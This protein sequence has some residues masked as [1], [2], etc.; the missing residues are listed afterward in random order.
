MKALVIASLT[1]SVLH[2]AA[3]ASSLLRGMLPSSW[4]QEDLQEQLSRHLE[5]TDDLDARDFHCDNENKFYF[6]ADIVLEFPGNENTC[7]AEMA[8]H[9]MT[10]DDLYCEIM[11]FLWEHF[12]DIVMLE[13]EMNEVAR[14]DTKVCEM[15]IARGRRNL[16]TYYGSGSCRW[17]YRKRRRLS[18]EGDATNM[19][20][21]TAKKL[22][23]AAEDAFNWAQKLREIAP[24]L[25]PI[26]PDGS[27]NV[28]QQSMNMDVAGMKMAED[29]EAV[30]QIIVTTQ[31]Y[32]EVY[33]ILA[34]L[35]EEVE[36]FLSYKAWAET[37]D[38]L[39]ETRGKQPKSAKEL[40]KT[41]SV[42]ADIHKLLNGLCKKIE[43]EYSGNLAEDT[44][45]EIGKAVDKLLKASDDMQKHA[46]E[47]DGEVYNLKA[48]ETTLKEA[49]QDAAAHI[50]SDCA[51]AI[52]DEIDIFQHAEA[53][54]KDI[55]IKEML[56]KITH[57]AAHDRLSEAADKVAGLVNNLAIDS[58]TLNQAVSDAM[59]KNLTCAVE[60]LTKSLELFEKLAVQ[61]AEDVL[62]DITKAREKAQE[63]YAEL[64]I[65]TM[66]KIL[67]K[68]AKYKKKRAS[69]DMM[70]S[71][72]SDVELWLESNLSDYLTDIFQEKYQMEQYSYPC[73]FND[74]KK[75]AIQVVVHIDIVD[76]P[77]E[78]A[79]SA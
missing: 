55:A 29:A 20:E 68:T 46:L 39:M 63:K 35:C 10:W 57:G 21:E 9:E 74:G 28:E 2:A 18:P 73:L 65:K 51:Q 58:M 25:A 64:L 23:E 67:S 53:D 60:V 36:E 37:S 7:P 5:L 12:D 27:K 56:E 62:H 71:A 24:Q 8:N 41:V 79:C 32:M 61:Q 52:K 40:D 69:F 38:A 30:D 59:D 47:M 14:L 33:P 13:G 77:S 66:Q 44:V 16:G 76:S 78:V 4:Q 26:E 34:E 31:N 45:A 72:P 1:V 75:K 50:I 22:R 54:T 43:K 70:S 6:N 42:E 48:S 17:C 11:T 19:Q 49:G 15:H 3:D